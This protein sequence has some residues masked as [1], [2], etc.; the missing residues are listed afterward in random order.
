[1]SKGSY[2]PFPEHE[3]HRDRQQMVREAQEGSYWEEVWTT[4]NLDGEECMSSAVHVL[5][6]FLGYTG[7]V[8]SR[9][10]ACPSHAG[11]IY[12]VYDPMMLPAAMRQRH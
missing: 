3:K 8:A 7:Y 6:F 11:D 5:G 1:M 10:G 4:C 12:P 9:A 2:G